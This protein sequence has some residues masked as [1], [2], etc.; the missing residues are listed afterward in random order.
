MAN[1]AVSAV[2]PDQP[3]SGDLLCRARAVSTN[4]GDDAIPLLPEAHQLPRPL[5]LAAELVQ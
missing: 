3:S 4:E 5:D 2:A 1:P